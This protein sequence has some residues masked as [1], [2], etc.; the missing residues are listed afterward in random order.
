MAAASQALSL[1]AVPDRRCRDASGGEARSGPLQPGVHLKLGVYFP[2]R[3]RHEGGRSFPAPDSFAALDFPFQQVDSGSQDVN[4]S[5]DPEPPFEALDPTLV[6]FLD[7]Q[8]FAHINLQIY[9]KVYHANW[10]WQS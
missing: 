9:T 3:W 1:P 8:G 4:L 2:A 7:H 5:L 6:L 10:I